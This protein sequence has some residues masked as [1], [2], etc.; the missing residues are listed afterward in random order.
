MIDIPKN[1]KH[2]VFDF[3]LTLVELLI[4]WEIMINKTRKYFYSIDQTLAK[5]IDNF[6]YDGYNKMIKKYGEDVKKTID[7]FY[8]EVENDKSREVLI[9]NQAFEFIKNNQNN[10]SFYIWSNNQR[11]TVE[12]ILKENNYLDLFKK[13]ITATDVSLFKPDI[14]GFNKI[15]YKNN[16]LEEYLMIGD[17]E[18]DKKAAENSK[19]DYY[20]LHI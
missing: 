11:L 7:D 3:D 17:S 9:N 15:Y 1:K 8:L 18:N 19:I 2:L 12:T 4:P 5:E 16:K 14:E 10:Y 20:Y 13:I 6:G